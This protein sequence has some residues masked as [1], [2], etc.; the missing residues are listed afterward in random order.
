MGLL[1]MPVQAQEWM[2]LE[3]SSQTILGIQT[4]FD[5][6]HNQDVLI[7]ISSTLGTFFWIDLA[8]SQNKFKDQTD[9]FNS[10]LS[11]AQLSWLASDYSEFRIAYQFE[12]EKKE[13]EVTQN[14][15]YI[16][17]K[18]YPWTASI[19]YSDGEVELFLLPAPFFNNALPSSIISDFSSTEIELSWWFDYYTLT[20]S[21]T[22]YD[23][24]K[25]ISLLSTKPIF[26]L[27]VKPKA[28]LHS[29]ILFAKEQKLSVQ[30]PLDQRSFELHYQLITSAVDNSKV[31]LISIDW[32][33]ALSENT[34]LL[35]SFTQPLNQSHSWAIA[36]GIE[37][38][39]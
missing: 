25:N 1:T 23:Y 28:L 33:E 39:F 2:G 19:Q 36:I 15:F 35:S 4:A 34:Q 32:I 37:W 13:L 5:N 24:E 6:N 14:Q 7:N 9:T 31:K 11:F 29:S 10:S 16:S 3:E 8:H 27:L 38:T 21:H 26:Q 20:L 30:I 18:P 12:G 22:K 17:Y